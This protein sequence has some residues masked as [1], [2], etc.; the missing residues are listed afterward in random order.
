M[1]KKVNDYK[2][3]LV[4]K[5]L[6][7]TPQRL[8]VLK[9]IDELHNHPT[10]EAIA[11]Y[12]RQT[13]PHVAVGTIYKVLDTL[14]E[15]ELVKRVK[16]E[17]DSMRYDGILEQHHHLY[18][19][20]SDRIEDYADHDLDTMLMEYFRRKNI[21]GFKIEEIKLQIKGHFMPA[22]HLSQNEK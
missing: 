11:E 4:L 16:T 14:V 8:A 5:G 22:R 12:V 20:E 19:A 3:Q 1:A 9:A 17:S 21:P 7:V 18:C 13:H 2:E 6:K 10:V 15:K